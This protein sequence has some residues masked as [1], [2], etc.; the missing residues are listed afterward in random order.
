[1][2]PN[3]IREKL[4]AGRPAVAISGPMTSDVADFLGQFGF[5]G[6]MLDGEH[7]AADWQM[8]ADVSRACDL[9]GMTCIVRVNSNSHGLIVRALD[10]G[11]GGVLVPHIKSRGD[12]EAVLSAA[13]FPPDGH[14]S[15]F[16]G[17]QSY[18][19][20]DYPWAANDSTLVCA[21]I[22][23]VQA[24][25]NLDAMLSEKRVDVFLIGSWDLAQSLGHLGEP[26]HPAVQSAIDD[27]VR[28]IV[29]AGRT[30]GLG[31]GLVDIPGAMRA[32]VRFFM[33][34]WTAWVAQGAKALHG[35]LEQSG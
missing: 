20:K 15:Y 26:G 10:R 25:D 28:K 8:V 30:A 21:M 2:R 5:D 34:S 12:I 31:G 3:R 9:W 7:G 1:M 29:A 27:T 24:L 16:P 23:D 18:G 4:A 33:V 19:A 13:L 6:V 11:A 17:R 32:G 22:E 35:V 14:R